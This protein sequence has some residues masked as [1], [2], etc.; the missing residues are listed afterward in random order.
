MD[1]AQQISST[2]NKDE[3]LKRSLGTL[4]NLYTDKTHFVYELL[5]NAEDAG[6]TAVFINQRAQYIEV[7]HD[8]LPFT[9]SNA[10]SL[11]D[12]ANSDKNVEGSTAIGKFGVGF[13]AV[14]AI[15]SRVEL[16]SEPSR[17]PI[18]DALPRFAFEILDYTNPVTI[19]RTWEIP[20]PFTTRFVFPYDFEGRYSSLK[21]LQLDIARKLKELGSDVL[22]F[23][24][25]IKEISY[26]I[27]GLGADTD[28]FGSY[29]LQTQ[30]ISDICTRISTFGQDGAVRNDNAYLKYSAPIR[31]SARTADIVFSCDFDGDTPLFRRS[32]H[33]N[34]YVFFPTGAESKLRFVVQAPFVTTPNRES[35][36]PSHPDNKRLAEDIAMLFYDA[37][38]DI[39]DR[40]WLTLDFLSLFPTSL[41]QEDWLY[42][43][44]YGAA[45]KL[46]DSEAV[47]PTIAGVC[48]TKE[49]ARIA[50]GADLTTILPDDKLQAILGRNAFWMPSSSPRRHNF[51][52]SDPELGP[53]YR[54]VANNC[55][56][57]ISPEMTPAMLRAPFLQ[58]VDEDWL[59]DYYNYLAR[60]AGAQFGDF[61]LI[62]FIKASDG[63]IVPASRL[64]DGALVPN[65][66]LRPAHSEKEI[67]GFIFVAP[68]IQ[69]KCREFCRAMDI[70][71]PEQIDYF[72]SE[73]ASFSREQSE[74]DEQNLKYFRRALNYLSDSN[75]IEVLPIRNSL[76]I[77]CLDTG[78]AA[79]YCNA[80]KQTVYFKNDPKG[81]PIFD[82]FSSTGLD[83]FVVDEDYY[84]GQGIKEDNLKRLSKAGVLGRIFDN[85]RLDEL[86]AVLKFIAGSYGSEASRKKSALLVRLFRVWSLNK[87]QK[88]A[89]PALIKTLN[90]SKWLYDKGGTLRSPAGMSRYD[91]DTSLYGPLDKISEVLDAFDFAQTNEDTKSNIRSLL[92]SLPEAE[93]NELLG[94]SQSLEPDEPE[95]ENEEFDESVARTAG[96]FPEEPL[97]GPSHLSHIQSYTRNQFETALP[98]EYETVRRR[99]R[100]SRLR[101]KE[102]IGNRYHGHCQLCE[103]ITAFWEV[104]EMFP[105]CPKEIEQFNLSLCPLCAA[106]YRHYR[107]DK[108]LMKGFREALKGA[109]PDDGENLVNVGEDSLRF[110][111]VHL[112]ELQAL[113]PL[114]EEETD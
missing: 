100:T 64:V 103:T 50:R 38:L 1:I 114:L 17:R 90:I 14:F 37:V 11:C 4:V 92:R 49:N 106:Q 18:P 95:G 51:T 61:R 56:S 23:L 111:A 26:S 73:L 80:D 78:G 12:A 19:N 3:M 87:Y 84:T 71:Q 94:S 31:D 110:T 7:L 109:N 10:Q 81:I 60:Q 47:Y 21:A 66:Y 35:I 101:D 41:N 57:V 67:A 99:V 97:R 59:A 88:D 85:G 16:Y 54:I 36:I 44:I 113:L 74:D 91:M 24:N 29:K 5:Q 63:R 15:C 104:T 48:V 20:E 93:R 53:V 30:K 75:D 43:P 34:S 42:R 112:A 79:R 39:R 46:L 72:N 108:G 13:K 62:P 107:K 28:A 77:R 65:V 105:D 8:G 25:N 32:P 96:K 9:M 45:R 33:L 68:F 102:Y 82:Y 69:R 76:R 70:P 6:A 89:W 40:N 55:V 22:L 2:Q 58:S 86:P 27:T 83:V 52:G 98:A